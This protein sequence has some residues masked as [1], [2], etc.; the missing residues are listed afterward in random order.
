MQIMDEYQT[1]RYLLTNRASIA[2]YGDGELKLCLG[3]S[4]KSQRADKD[5]QMRLLDI[6]KHPDKGNCVVG[7]PR[8]Y[9]KEDSGRMTERKW[10]FWCNYATKGFLALYDTTKMYGSAFITRP[11]TNAGIDCKEYYDEL[12]SI[13]KDRDVLVMHG[14]GTGFLKRMSLLDGARSYN[15]IHGPI[16]DA[17]TYHKLL[18][19]G[20]MDNSTNKSVILL[21]LGPEATVLAYD[22]AMAGRQALD[23]GHL[24]MFYAHIHPK[25]KNWDGVKRDIC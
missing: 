13:W 18:M 7:I 4:A 2:R 25:D 12:K 17:F 15:I 11:D 22:L 5:M 24:G 3:K 1:I 9:A 23:L 20:L 19:K 6:L 10:S 8:I 14:E 21:S 16:R